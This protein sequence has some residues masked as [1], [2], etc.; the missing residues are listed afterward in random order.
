MDFQPDFE[1]FAAAYD[2]GQAQVIWTRLPADLDTPVSLMLKL[3]QAGPES[4]LLE[5]VT[6]GAQR[7]RYSIIG[8]KPDVIWRCRGDKAEINHSAAYDR[9]A[10]EPDQERGALD[11][12]RALIAESRI[13]LPEDLPA[14]AAGLFGYLGYDMARL[15]ERLPEPNKDTLGLPDAIMLRPSLVAVVDNAFDRL[16]LVAPVRPKPGVSAREAYGRAA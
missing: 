8:W 10:F 6:G 1:T 7:G 3:T 11:S 12:L 5:S 9:D 14:S 16:T 4:F 2:K 15:V 13:E